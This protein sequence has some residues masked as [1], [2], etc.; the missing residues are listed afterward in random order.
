[1]VVIL[2]AFA[3][4]LGAQAVETLTNIVPPRSAA[5]RVAAPQGGSR[6]LG[7]PGSARPFSSVQC[8]V[9]YGAA[10]SAIAVVKRMQGNQPQMSQPCMYERIGLRPGIKPLK[11]GISLLREYF[12]F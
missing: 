1:M 7:R 12:G 8:H 10:D 11:K 5:A 3:L 4:Y 9:A 6:A 2:F